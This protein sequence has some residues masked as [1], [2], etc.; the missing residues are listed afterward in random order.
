MLVSKKYLTL[1]PIIKIFWNSIWLKFQ[2]WHSRK[3]L[4]TYYHLLTNFSWTSFELCTDLLHITY[5][6]LT[7]YKCFMNILNIK[8]L[9]NILLT[10][11]ILLLNLLGTWYELHINFLR[12]SYERLTNLYK[13]LQI[14][15]QTSYK[16]LVIFVWAFIWTSYKLLTKL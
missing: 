12:I 16:W 4:Q 6:L 9:T 2:G 8:S 15:L 5:K 10:F 7:S 3:F 11:H 14:F 1:D 13:L